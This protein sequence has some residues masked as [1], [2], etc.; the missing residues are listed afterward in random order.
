VGNC[1]RSVKLTIHPS[2]SDDASITWGF[3]STD[4][5]LLHGVVLGYKDNLAFH[6]LSVFL[7]YLTML[8]FWLE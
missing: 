6:V 8:F 4:T 7:V 5:L 3:T 1:S 2:F